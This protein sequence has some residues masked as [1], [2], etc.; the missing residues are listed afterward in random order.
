MTD[1]EDI[2]D[3]LDRENS[4]E[5]YEKNE[6]LYKENRDIEQ[7]EVLIKKTSNAMEFTPDQI[8]NNLEKEILE[9][10]EIENP[11]DKYIENIGIEN[12]NED[13]SDD[14]PV[15]IVIK[16]TDGTE[17]TIVLGEK[18]ISKEKLIEQQL[19]E[20][21]EYI[22]S[23]KDSINS[24]EVKKGSKYHKKIP[25]KD[26]INKE[27]NTTNYSS[28]PEKLG[29]DII[30]SLLKPLKV[31]NNYMA[32]NRLEKNAQTIKPEDEK[33]YTL[34]INGEEYQFKKY[35]ED[36]KSIIIQD[37]EG[38]QF[39]VLNDKNINFIIGPEKTFNNMELDLL[40]KGK[41]LIQSSDIPFKVFSQDGTIKFQTITSDDYIKNIDVKAQQVKSKKQSNKQNQNL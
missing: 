19:I 41:S 23:N 35:S 34:G 16:N 4:Y 6:Y 3:F 10:K 36:Y 26:F 24:V 40:N 22:N 2:D 18:E 29:E 20:L 9:I 13:L 39:E 33:L 32:Q 28:N 31:F 11:I 30:L 38:K 5:A 17:K 15:S 14:E 37:K 25:L 1:F 12:N 7:K 8:E 27:L 21:K